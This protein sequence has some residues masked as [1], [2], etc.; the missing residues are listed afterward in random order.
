RRLFIGIVRDMTARHEVERLK[1]DFVSTV[2]H[3]LRTPLTSIAGSL[4][5]LAGAAAGELP[6]KAARLIEIARLN[7]ERLVRLINDLLEPQRLKPLVQHA[8]DLNRAYAH[9]F[10]VSIELAEGADPEVLV[11]RDRLVQVIT[12]ILSN[13]AKFSPQGAVVH[14]SIEVV[15]DQARVSVKD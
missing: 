2:S 1:T 11:D 10:G 7:C 8:I 9:N 4:G 12:N 5:L 14:V 13:A 6:D 3:E 15:G